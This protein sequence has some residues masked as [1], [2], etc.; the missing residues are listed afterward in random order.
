M[1]SIT[2]N[3]STRQVRSTLT[4]KQKATID[5][6]LNECPG[7]T[8]ESVNAFYQNCYMYGWHIYIETKP[9][10]DYSPR[11]LEVITRCDHK[12]TA[13]DKALVIRAY[14]AEWIEMHSVNGG[15]NA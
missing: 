8:P 2:P 9:A 6:L 10:G 7:I 11:E 15:D 13:K 1:N 4:K 14:I 3:P 12:Y 5:R